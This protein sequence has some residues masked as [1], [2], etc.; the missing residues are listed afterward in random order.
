MHAVTISLLSRSN[1]SQVEK[2]SGIRSILTQLS[3]GSRSS[4]RP[5]PKS[6]FRLKE[7]YFSKK[8]CEKNPKPFSKRFPL[9]Y[10]VE[11]RRQANFTSS[12]FFHTCIVSAFSSSYSGFGLYS[13]DSSMVSISPSASFPPLSSLLS[14]P[15]SFLRTVPKES[16]IGCSKS[17][18]FLGT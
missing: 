4:I 11:D 14:P 9:P 1:G 6:R 2:I 18:G 5:I 7:S 13:R 16:A 10:R 12:L 8:T 15:T 3:Q 17:S